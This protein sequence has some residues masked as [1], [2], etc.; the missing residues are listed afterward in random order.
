[1]INFNKVIKYRRFNRPSVFKYAIFG[2]DFNRGGVNLERTVYILIDCFSYLIVLK[3]SLTSGG[4][5]F[6][7]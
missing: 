6:V 7:I 5:Y 2:A 1:M 4:I 3:Y